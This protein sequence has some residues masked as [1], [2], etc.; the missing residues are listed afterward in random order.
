MESV[1]DSWDEELMVRELTEYELH[2]LALSD[3]I[4]LVPDGARMPFHQVLVTAREKIEKKY[5][6]MGYTELYNAYNSVFNWPETEE[7]KI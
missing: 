1:N 7:F 6:N 2:F 3:L 4:E 5:R